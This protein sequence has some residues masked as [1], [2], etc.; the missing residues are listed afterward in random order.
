MLEEI[1]S[2]KA[3]EAKSKMM[4]TTPVNRNGTDKEEGKDRAQYTGLVLAGVNASWV[5]DPIVDTLRNINF[6]ALPGEFVGVAGPVG[7]GKVDQR[8]TSTFDLQPSDRSVFNRGIE[9]NIF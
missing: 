2:L 7:S 1:G 8:T 3:I 9:S 6:T 5:R 4:D